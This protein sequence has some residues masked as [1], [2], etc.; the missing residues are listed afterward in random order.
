[1]IGRYGFGI[2]L[3]GV[4]EDGKAGKNRVVV[5]IKPE[6][7]IAWNFVKLNQAYGSKK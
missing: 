4:L 3:L 6:K 2:Y 5:K 7:I 1:M